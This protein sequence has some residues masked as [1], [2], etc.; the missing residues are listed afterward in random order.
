MSTIILGDRIIQ[1]SDPIQQ[2]KQ[3]AQS[4]QQA[5]I[6]SLSG[7]TTDDDRGR[8]AREIQRDAG[9]QT[10]TRDSDR[11]KEEKTNQILKNVGIIDEPEKKGIVQAGQDLLAKVS[12]LA[13]FIQGTQSTDNLFKKLVGG[14]E[15]GS[16][17]KVTLVNL[18]DRLGSD[19]KNIENLIKKYADQNKLSSSEALDLAGRFNQEYSDIGSTIFSSGITDYFDRMDNMG[20]GETIKTMAG[21]LTGTRDTEGIVTLENVTDNLGTEGLQFL[22]TTNPEAYYRL[23]PNDPDLANESFVSTGDPVAD[24]RFNA[25]IMEARALAADKQSRQD[26]NTGQGIMASSPAFASPASQY[27]I[28]IGKPGPFIG[29]FVDTDGDGIDDR[30]QT[31]PGQPRQ[32]FVNPKAPLPGTSG[33]VQPVAT[34]ITPFDVRQFY[35][36]LPQYTQQGIM[37]PNLAQFYQNLGMFPGMNV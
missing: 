21:D 19:P 13:N 37:N 7:R 8:Q 31:G 6:G 35:A 33:T 3:A 4:M 27:G 12:P 11:D 1:T 5:G 26:A 29:N 15:L 20:L 14:L 9:V 34:G 17:D 32:P 36:S 10:I 30:F 23:R 22:K 18:V 28:F 25:K 2:R 24:R 16:T